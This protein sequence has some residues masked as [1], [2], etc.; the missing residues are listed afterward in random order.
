MK[1]KKRVVA[2]SGGF[3]PIHIGHIKLLREAKKLGDKL[4]VLLNTDDWLKKKKGLVF[5][6]YNERKEI[7]ESIKY[8]DEVVPVI[9]ENGTVAET[10]AQL[11]PDIFAKGGDRRAENMPKKELE[12][13]QKLRIK[14][15]YNVG[16]KKIQSSSWLIDILKGSK[17]RASGK[18]KKV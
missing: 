13:C 3:D 5:M 4:V 2:T 10:L 16:G 17:G 14:I 18:T 9:D 8:V 1:R 15:V 7:I 12:T 11:K 6:P